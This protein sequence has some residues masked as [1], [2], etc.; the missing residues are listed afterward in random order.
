[1][2]LRTY[3]NTCK[4]H[5]VVAGTEMLSHEFLTADRAVQRTRFSGG[6]TVVVNFGSEPYRARLGKRTLLLPRN[7][8]AVEGPHFTQSL[9][10]EGG[11]AVTTIRGAHYAYTDAK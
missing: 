2:F 3:R 11:R 4:L 1:M 9:A 7:G 6:T 8:F 5:E 10:L